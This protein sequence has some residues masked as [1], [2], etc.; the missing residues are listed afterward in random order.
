MQG[1]ASRGMA[2]LVWALHGSAR[3]GFISEGIEMLVLK[4]SVDERILIG[5]EI[6]I[7]LC[8][9][10]KGAAYIGVDAP[11]EVAVDREEIRHAKEEESQ[12]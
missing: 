6:V 1:D 12:N 4:R 7:T 9:T 2:R 3:H 11:K 10:V 5:D 8:R